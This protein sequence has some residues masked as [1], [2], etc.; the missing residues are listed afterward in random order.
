[1]KICHIRSLVYLYELKIQ[2]E[3]Q[4]I[5]LMKKGGV[6]THN[7]N[8]KRAAPLLIQTGSGF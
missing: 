8:P 4:R 3:A 2:F 7:Y 5:P 1:M 6:S